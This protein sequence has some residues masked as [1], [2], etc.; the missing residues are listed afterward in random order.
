M[1]D[2]DFPW[3][4]RE[5]VNKRAESCCECTA[6]CSIHPTGR[7]DM[8]FWRPSAANFRAKDPNGLPVTDNCIMLC[9]FCLRQAQ[10]PK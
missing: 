1:A 9:N 6:G 2:L 7:C 3:E 10:K 5:F 8:V 4:V